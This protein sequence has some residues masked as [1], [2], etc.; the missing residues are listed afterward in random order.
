MKLQYN[1]NLASLLLHQHQQ[2]EN[3]IIFSLCRFTTSGCNRH[4]LI[5]MA[6][7]ME[8]AN[9]ACLL[10]PLLINKRK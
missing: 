9:E 5:T 1:Q 2:P 7:I 8:G 4:C 3:A 10:L 6:T